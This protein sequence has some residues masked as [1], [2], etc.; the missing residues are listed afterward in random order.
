MNF[1]WKLI[2][3]IKLLLVFPFILYNLYFDFSIYKW[4]Y[5]LLVNLL[6]AL[7]CV[8]CDNIIDVYF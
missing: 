2:S 8:T 7:L 1:D 6:F 4:D 3:V 5:L